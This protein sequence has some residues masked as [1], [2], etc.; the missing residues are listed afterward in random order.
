MCSCDHFLDEP[1]CAVQGCP[2]V[3]SVGVAPTEHYC[4]RHAPVVISDE[5]AA[6]AS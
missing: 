6:P 5:P 2:S 3:A 1:Q 4:Y